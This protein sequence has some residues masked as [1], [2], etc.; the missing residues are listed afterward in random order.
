MSKLSGSR[1]LIT[2]G[3][4]FIGSHLTKKIVDLYDFEKILLIDKNINNSFFKKNSKITSEEVDITNIFELSKTIKDF[5]PTHVF[6]LS[7]YTS[8]NRGIEECN[9]SIDVNLKGT[10]NVIETTK[11]PD[12]EV[13]IHIGT[14]EVY[15]NNHPPFNEGMSVVPNSPYSASKMSSEIFSNMLSSNYDLPIVFLRPFNVYGEGQDDKML[16]P[17]VIKKCLKDQKIDLTGGKQTRE[18]NYVGDIVDGII[19]S[20]ITKE[21]IGEIINLGS[22]KDIEV[23]LLVEKI[24]HLTQSNSILNFGALSYRKNEIW[25]MYC[26]TSKSEKIL[27]WKCKIG[28]EEGLLKTIKWYKQNYI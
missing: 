23:R 2:G 24:K 7:A 11:N 10:C 28:L 14:S 18:S 1:I 19:K 27:G 22:G 4:G 12:L 9:N 25:K 15:G 13:F 8:N 16:I 17:Y 21:A 26:D 3:H 5:L 20:S 6:H